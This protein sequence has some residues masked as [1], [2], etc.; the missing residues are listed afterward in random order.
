MDQPAPF[1]HHGRAREHPRAHRSV[2]SRWPPERIS[3]EDGINE[4]YDAVNEA[5]HYFFQFD[6]EFQQDTHLIRDYCGKRLL[7]AIWA[8]KVQP[9]R[10]SQSQ[11]HGQRGRFDDER[12]REGP[13]SD[14]AL[15]LDRLLSSLR[16]ALT[17]AEGTRPS[18]RRPSRDSA[19][20]A[21][22]VQKQLHRSF[23]NIR[24]SY[25]LVMERRSEMETVNT[26]LEMLRVFLSR[27]GAEEGRWRGKPDYFQEEGG[28]PHRSDSGGSQLEESVDQPEEW[29]GGHGDEPADTAVAGDAARDVW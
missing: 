9:R 20:D 8:A 26:E 19:E 22:K 21:A 15:A 17:I 11:Q 16:A 10:Q 18:Q 13:V 12:I 25:S 6:Q 4:L 28:P 2:Q 1:P 5:I 14:F 7:E 29:T 24:K 23:Q 3:L 27:N